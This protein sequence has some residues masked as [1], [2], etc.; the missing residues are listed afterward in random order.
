VPRCRRV[1]EH[2]GSSD[3]ASLQQT[4]G[5]S[6]KSSGKDYLFAGTKV[7]HSRSKLLKIKCFE[8]K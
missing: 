5:V 4:Q 8:A 6:P 3:R 2:R 7:R 1:S